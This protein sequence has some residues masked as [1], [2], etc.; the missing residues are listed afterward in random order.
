[1]S[2][3]LPA[4]L[5]HDL[6]GVLE[7]I[8][9]LKVHKELF[10]RVQIDVVDGIFARGKTFDDPRSLPELGLDLEVHMLVNHPELMMRGW[11]KHPDVKRI[12]VHADSAG[13]I[14]QLITQIHE[15]G[16]EISLACNPETPSRVFEPFVT[17][18]D[19]ILL[20][21]VTPGKQ[22][23]P[24]N[25]DVLEKA[26]ELKKNWPTVPLCLDGGINMETLNRVLRSQ[27]DDLVIG[28]AIW[29]APKPEQALQA[30]AARIAS[31]PI[32]Y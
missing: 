21:S 32:Q 12:I 25:K 6:S 23:Q 14:E 16:K 20:L 17:K 24:M 19:G 2:H 15:A 28:S 4:I 30:L 18:V 7:K 3:L 9:L 10:W 29:S 8:E 31:G 22:G 1:M 5:E 11:L 27:I 26:R 13:P